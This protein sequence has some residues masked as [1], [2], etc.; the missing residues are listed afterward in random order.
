MS[1]QL[2]FGPAIDGGTRLGGGAIISG[3]GR[4][5]YEL[6]RRWDDGGPLLEWIMLNP[7]TADA[8]QDDPTVRRCIAFAKRWGYGGIVVHN[9]YALRATSPGVLIGYGTRPIHAIGPDNLDY[10][11][12]DDAR[13]ADCTIAA[14]GAHAAGLWWHEFGL[15]IERDRL[16]CLGTNQGGSPKHPLYVPSSRTPIPWEAS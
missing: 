15:R 6:T 10:L 5:R 11:R 7:S 1:E 16:F 12:S 13:R 8:D 14:W 4:Y 3:C 2:E 9:L